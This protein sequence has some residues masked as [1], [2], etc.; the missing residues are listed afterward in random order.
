[1][2]HFDHHFIRQQKENL[3]ISMKDLKEVTEEIKESTPLLRIQGILKIRKES[4]RDFLYRFFTEWNRDKN[5]LFAQEVEDFIADPTG[6]EED[7]EQTTT[8]DAKIGEI[9]CKPD[10]RRS[11][12]DVFMICKY[13][14]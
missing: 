10:K 5:T 9:A 11:L 4:L 1:M 12:G 14:I 13:Y 6:Y 7:D 2:S 8:I 3:E